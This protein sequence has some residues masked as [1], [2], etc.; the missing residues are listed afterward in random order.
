MSG[1][2]RAVSRYRSNGTYFITRAGK[3]KT[4]DKGTRRYNL[5]S[6]SDVFTTNISSE[7]SAQQLQPNTVFEAAI[8]EGELRFPSL[9]RQVSELIDKRRFRVGVVFPGNSCNLFAGSRH[10]LR[11]VGQ[12]AKHPSR[13]NTTVDLTSEDGAND[14]LQSVVNG[15]FRPNTD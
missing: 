11:V 2:E 10:P 12:I 8:E 13:V 14:K 6:N 1:K 9:D 15:R 7:S 3:P 4:H 5:V